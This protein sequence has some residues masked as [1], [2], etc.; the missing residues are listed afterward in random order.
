MLHFTIKLALI[1]F[2]HAYFANF[3]GLKCGILPDTLYLKRSL[4]RK[5]CIL[6]HLTSAGIT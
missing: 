5:R 4:N 2:C 3:D 6:I 1:A